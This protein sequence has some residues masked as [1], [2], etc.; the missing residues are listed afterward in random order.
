MTKEEKGKNNFVYYSESPPNWRPPPR[1]YQEYFLLKLLREVLTILA[2]EMFLQER[3]KGNN[4]EID[5]IWRGIPI[6]VDFLEYDE[7]R[8]DEIRKELE[9][10]NKGYY[11]EGDKKF[12]LHS[13]FKIMRDMWCKKQGEERGFSGE[14]AVEIGFDILKERFSLDMSREEAYKR[15]L[16]IVNEWE[17]GR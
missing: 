14:R 9:R 6:L 10:I 11:G 13:A 7:K 4:I 8:Y 1:E 3:G 15:A 17:W 16:E 2:I 5:D 12:S